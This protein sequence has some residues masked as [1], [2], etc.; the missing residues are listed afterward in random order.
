MWLLEGKYFHIKRKP[1]SVIVPSSLS[2]FMPLTNSYYSTL[3]SHSE[4]KT[5]LCAYHSFFLLI[6]HIAH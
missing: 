2:F 1:L 3:I 5:P 6:F 4:Y